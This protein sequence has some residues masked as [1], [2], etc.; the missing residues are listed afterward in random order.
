MREV[1]PK[2]DHEDRHNDPDRRHYQYCPEISDVGFVWSQTYEQ[3]E[4]RAFREVKVD[5]IKY[6]A[7]I[8]RLHGS[9][10][11]KEPWAVMLPFVLP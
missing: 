9:G 6:V 4:D 11:R 3:K 8:S 1:A 2:G 7:G 5:K 10:L